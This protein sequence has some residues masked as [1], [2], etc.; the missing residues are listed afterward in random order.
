MA[1]CSDVGGACALLCGSKC[2]KGPGPSSRSQPLLLEMAE[3]PEDASKVPSEIVF[4]IHSC[5]YRTRP[6]RPRT[7]VF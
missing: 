3:W 2:L 4:K 6:L 1:R 7:S 5:S